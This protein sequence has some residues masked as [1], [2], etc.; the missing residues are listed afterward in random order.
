MVRRHVLPKKP[1]NRSKLMLQLCVMSVPLFLLLLLLGRHL[2]QKGIG[3]GRVTLSTSGRISAAPR[4]PPSPCFGSSFSTAICHER[5]RD[6]MSYTTLLEYIFLGEC[7]EATQL[8]LGRRLV[9]VRSLQT[10]VRSLVTVATAVPSAA[11]PSICVRPAFRAAIC[12]RKTKP[13]W[14]NAISHYAV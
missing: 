11:F 1:L 13:R 4:S 14:A 12:R 10:R 2:P 8:G 5:H 6:V 9:K 3:L 7:K